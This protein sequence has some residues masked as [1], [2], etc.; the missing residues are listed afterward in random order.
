M[1]NPFFLDHSKLFSDSALGPVGKF[2]HTQ[3][4]KESTQ[5]KS[6]IMRWVREREGETSN[7]KHKLYRTN[8]YNSKPNYAKSPP[9]RADFPNLQFAKKNLNLWIMALSKLGVWSDPGRPGI[10]LLGLFGWKKN[11]SGEY[12]P[13]EDLFISTATLPARPIHQIPFTAQFKSSNG[14]KGRKNK[15]VEHTWK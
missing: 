7:H 5:L 12:T 14:E 15:D 13:K 11:Q 10:L 6:V 3:F 1:V 8:T 9:P 2:Y 4:E